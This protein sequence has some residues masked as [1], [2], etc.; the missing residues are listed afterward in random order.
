M[1]RLL[2]KTAPALMLALLLAAIA[3][4][5]HA[6]T[7]SVSIGHNDSGDITLNFHLPGTICYYSGSNTYF[8]RVELSTNYSSGTVYQETKLPGTTKHNIGCETLTI[9]ATALNK[10]S[11]DDN[12]TRSGS[13]EPGI[14]P[15]ETYVL[16][17]T[18]RTSG[19]GTISKTVSWTAPD[20]PPDYGP[21]LEVKNSDGL[22]W[23]PSDNF[24]TFPDFNQNA[25]TEKYELRIGHT[26]YPSDTAQHGLAGTAAKGET[27]A[28]G[29]GINV[30]PNR[31][32]RLRM[33]QFPNAHRDAANFQD[34]DNATGK[35]GKLK[36]KL[37]SLTRP[38]TTLKEGTW[39]YRVNRPVLGS[40]LES[41]NASIEIHGLG[42]TPGFLPFPLRWEKTPIAASDNMLWTLNGPGSSGGAVMRH[43]K[44][45]SFTQTCPTTPK[46]R[47]NNSASIRTMVPVET[48]GTGASLVVKEGITLA[49]CYPGVV[50]LSLWAADSNATLSALPDS[51]KLMVRF[52][53]AANLTALH[54]QISIDSGYGYSNLN[55]QTPT[56]GSLLRPTP[57]PPATFPPP[58]P[59]PAAAATKEAL[60]YFTGDAPQIQSLAIEDTITAR[61]GR[62]TFLVGITWSYIQGAQ[63][64]QLSVEEEVDSQPRII[65]ANDLGSLEK[66]FPTRSNSGT[67]KIKVRG[68]V[69]CNPL[70]ETKDCTIKTNQEEARVIR[71]GQQEYT[72]WSPEHS[73]ELAQLNI[74]LK[75]QDPP[76]DVPPGSGRYQ[77]REG[78]KTPGAWI[79]DTFGG[80]FG[81]TDNSSRRNLAITAWAV[82]CLAG[83]VVLYRKA[84]EMS[85][86]ESGLSPIGAAAAAVWLILT[87]SVLGYV[88]I[89]LKIGTAALPVAAVLFIIILRTWNTV[90]SG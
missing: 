47:N 60:N 32:L 76:L 38:G 55:R 44:D 77:P 20:A 26:A 13:P 56:P 61:N 16:K 27:C 73:L 78:F 53:F 45:S 14:R 85:G 79:G 24:A 74:N 70:H 65:E 40:R 11:A 41:L 75:P 30:L 57:T 2:A 25:Y 59:T 22:L 68:A 83:A 80:L 6:Q 23:P 46:D 39:D 3:Q 58:T 52:P 15:K 81:F 86:N 63:R 67:L 1:T 72:R 34:P 5:G 43:A 7:A 87:W 10:K 33:C 62:E 12:T 18:I 54:R 35:L 9:P 21:M 64:Y 48:T 69:Y 36:Y 82:F 50:S 28:A 37:V 51:R 49:L 8:Y 29:E 42:R 89:D 66:T 90:R 31:K 4:D 19:G 88:F 84:W 17:Y 71:N